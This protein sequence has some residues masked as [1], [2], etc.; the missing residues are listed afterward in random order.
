V[1]RGFEQEYSVDFKKTFASVVKPM[2]YRALF[3]IA[4]ALNWQ[5]DQMDVKTAFLYG[6]ID[7]EVYVELPLNL[8]SKYPVDRV[9]KLNKALYGLKQAPKIWYDTLCK[10]L[11]AL[12]FKNINKDYS[13]F[14]HEKK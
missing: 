5:I 4:C 10:E 2:S 14:V 6:K 13:I 8:K 3:A 12:G 7:A 11:R 1:A 9:C